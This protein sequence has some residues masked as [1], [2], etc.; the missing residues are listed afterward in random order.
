MHYCGKCDWVHGCDKR[1]YTVECDTPSFGVIDSFP[2][3]AAVDCNNDAVQ[4]PSS[5]TLGSGLCSRASF[6]SV[7][8][9]EVVPRCRRE[10]PG[11]Q[12][13]PE[14]QRNATDSR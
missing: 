10:D 12:S 13:V 6:D 11:W 4:G 8:L 7:R 2:F 14:H 9:P 5:A 3:P 1:P